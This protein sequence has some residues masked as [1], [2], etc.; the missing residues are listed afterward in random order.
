MSISHQRRQGD[1]TVDGQQLDE[2]KKLNKPELYKLAKE[3]A[4]GAEIIPMVLSWVVDTNGSASA[5]I[6]FGG[7]Y[8][9]TFVITHN[10]Y[11][12]GDGSN[13]YRRSVAKLYDGGNALVKS[14]R[15]SHEDGTATYGV[16]VVSITGF[17]TAAELSKEGVNQPSHSLHIQFHG[18]KIGAPSE[19]QLNHLVTN[20][21]YKLADNAGNII[22]IP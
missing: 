8:F 19:V 10:M 21:G 12:I 3:M 13:D 18:Y 6:D 7:R 22:S 1:G 5:S 17:A 9:G 15:G 14:L 16:N 11:N 4:F 20:L 2:L